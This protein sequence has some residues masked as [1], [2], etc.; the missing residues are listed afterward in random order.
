LADSMVGSMV[1]STAEWKVDLT[2]EKWAAWLDESLV[3]RMVSLKAAH[4]AD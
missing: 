3:G 4:S 1:G 2:A